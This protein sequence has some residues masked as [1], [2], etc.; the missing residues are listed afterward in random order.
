[1]NENRPRLGVLLVTSGWFRDVGLQGA[2]SDT[3]REVAQAGA[4]IVARIE[5]FADTVYAG[6]LFSAADAQK[7]AEKICAADV[8]GVLLA[9]LM[10]C[11]DEIPRAALS[12]LTGLPLV[13][14]TCS[15]GPS[16]PPFVPFQLMIR[17]SGPV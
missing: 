15:P 4:E 16:L 3:T 5:K 6:V 7:A 13:L 1:M 14:W 11:E 12:L 17:G 9:P 2:G 8:D 10:W